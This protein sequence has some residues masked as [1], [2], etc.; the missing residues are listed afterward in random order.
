MNVDLKWVLV[1][2]IFLAVLGF[3]VGAG[4]QFTDLG[5]SPKEVK[6]VIALCV[7]LLGAGNSVNSV[8]VAF[9][10][11]S[12]GRLASAEQVPLAQKLDSLADNNPDVK[13][14]VTTQAIA[15]ATD[16]DKVVGPPKATGTKV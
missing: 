8:L 6:A 16:S 5:L 9:G 13:S 4:S 1:L 3:L 11:T 15:E 12:A 7:L 2:S 14:I 10:M